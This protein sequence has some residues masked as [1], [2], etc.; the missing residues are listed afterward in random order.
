MPNLFKRL[1]ST[2]SM[3]CP[4][5]NKKIITASPA[6]SEIINLLGEVIGIN[7]IK[8]KPFSLYFYLSGSVSEDG[9]ATSINEFI[10]NHISSIAFEVTFFNFRSQ[11]M[12]DENSRSIIAYGNL[13]DDNCIEVKIPYNFLSNFPSGQYFLQLLMR[14]NTNNDSEDVVLIENAKMIINQGGSL[15]A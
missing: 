14:V 9:I 10:L 12:K 8:N 5:C 11:Q 13:V 6:C 3:G 2:F 4:K 7:V 1:K 15:D